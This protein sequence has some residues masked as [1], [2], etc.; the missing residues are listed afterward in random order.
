M[1]QKLFI[2]IA[3]LMGTIIGAGILGIP[4]VVAKAGF[5]TGLVVIIGIGIAAMVVNLYLGEVILRT[6]GAHQLPGYAFK[7]LGKWGKDILTLSMVFGIYGA[8][9]AY[10]IGEGE[11]LKAIFGG[12]ALLYSLTFYAVFAILVYLGLRTVG[13]SELIITNL[14]IVLI[15]LISIICIYKIEPSNF[16]SFSFSRLFIPYGVVLFAFWGSA[17]I[18]EVNEIL[19][20]HRSQVKKAIIIGSLI[21]LVVY[22]VFAVMVVGVVGAEG[23]FSLQPNERVATVALSRFVEGPI[24]VFA[25]LFAIAAMATSFLALGIAL[26]Q[27]FNYDYGINEKL[28]YLL[29]LGVP[30]VVFLTNN[31]LSISSFIGALEIA[32]VIAGGIA[33][34]VIILMFWKAKRAGERKPEFSIHKS[35]FVGVLLILLFLFGIIYEVL[36]LTGVLRI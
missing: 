20:K 31:Y 3:T 11:A 1:Y 26:K 27:M 13:K 22:L 32:G 17:A 24:G 7:Y 21:P 18:P 5:L 14:I 23:F 29:V 16:T 25:N 6:K 33:G 34:M 35:K 36:K 10:T 28:S 2:A 8:L 12:S 30:L 9:I 4:Y 19:V 15:I